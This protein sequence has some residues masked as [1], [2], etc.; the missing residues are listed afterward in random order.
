MNSL[1]LQVFSDQSQKTLEFLASEFSGLQVGRASPLL[2]ENISIKAY[3]GEQQI[4]AFAT[5][6]VDGPQSIVVS[7]WDKSILSAIEKAIRDDASLGLS[8]VN[9]GVCVRLNIPNL[10]E[11]RRR[12]LTKLVSR[13]AEEA[14]IS[15]RKHRHEALE[16]IKKDES[17]SEDMQKTLEKELQKK[18]DECNQSIDVAENRKASEIMKV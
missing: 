11:E 5:I 12:D 7:P 3:G 13:M 8:P 6:T 14:K 9:D 18:V 17:L 2:V 15:I 4:K 16:K 1:I 10:T